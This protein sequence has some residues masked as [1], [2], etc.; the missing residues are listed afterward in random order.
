MAR[1]IALRT[2]STV[3]RKPR[4]EVVPPTKPPLWVLAVVGVAALVAAADLAL[5]LAVRGGSARPLRTGDEV[6]LIDPATG[7]VVKRIGVGHLATAVVAGFGS[8]WVLNRGDGSVTR[9]DAHSRRVDGTI[10]PDATAT[11]ITAGS[12]GLWFAGPP[13]TGGAQAPEVSELERINPQTG[14]VDRRF[15]THTGA[16][17]IAAGGGGLWST[18]Y[19]GGH[20][21]GAARSDPTTGAMRRLDIGIYG[22]LIAANDAAVYWVASASSR[23]ARVST[24][25]GRLTASLTLASDASLAAGV[26]P[27]NPTAVVVGGGS[28]WISTVGGSVLRVDIALRRVVARIQVCRNAIELAYGEGA[29]WVACTNGDVV[30]LDPATG[31]PGTTIRVG[32]LPHGIA[33]GEGGV[34]VT[35]NR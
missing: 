2:F 11:D 28:V 29:V 20:I 8:I 24:R 5:F 25:S 12:G 6:A 13:R 33:A 22:D 14:A 9:I 31:R 16:S 30:R 19:L 10:E 34:W 23:I 3:R 21:R 18:G 15:E 17:I 7:A 35:L 26:V 1:T 32:G 4:L 27:P